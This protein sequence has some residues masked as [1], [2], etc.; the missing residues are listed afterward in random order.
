MSG[1][2]YMGRHVI[3]DL[4]DVSAEVLGS[5]D[6][7]KEILIDG[8]KKSGATVLSDH[9]HHF[10]EGYGI[11]GVIVLAES[12]ISIHT[13]PEKNYAAID[14]FMCGTCDPEV[15]VDHITSKINTFVKKDLIYRK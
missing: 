8:A 7:W 2:S 10:G 14:V 9:F 3:A 15:A 4:H 12:H 13:W 11:T 6:F 5:I 1:V